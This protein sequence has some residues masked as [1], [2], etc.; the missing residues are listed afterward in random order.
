MSEV[1]GAIHDKWQQLGGEAGFFGAA[2]DIERPTF[3][4]VGRAQEFTGGTISWHPEI[5]AFA[6]WGWIRARWLEIGRENFGYP[7]NDESGCPDGRGRYNHYRA[8]HLPDR[9]D[10]SIYWTESTGAHEVYGGIRG[11]WRDIGWEK[12]WLGYPTEHEADTEAGGRAQIFEHGNMLWWPDLGAIEVGD[13]AIRYRGMI[14]FGEDDEAGSDEPYVIVGVA[15]AD[16]HP[17]PSFSRH[18]DKVDAGGSFP[19]A[20]DIYRG[21]PN[22]VTLAV[23][24]ME[25]DEGDPAAYKEKVD[26]L[27]A[28]AMAAAGLTGMAIP[29]IGP[30]IGPAITAGLSA[31]APVVAKEVTSWL[32]DELI[33]I[34]SIALTQ[35]ELCRLLV[36][37]LQREQ[38]VQFHIPTILLSNGAASYKAYFDVV[39]V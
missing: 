22:G 25:H 28:G 32:A 39:R 35:K 26:K 18:Y 5:G 4:G 10:S 12:G 9:P 27:V 31:L 7:L 15:A 29:V 33:G 17:R 1:I 24:L 37:P 6:T 30:F 19:E 11:R 34:Q 20:T 3:D 13:I 38:Q 14:C 36:A 23:T 2:L 8:M 16:G 21:L